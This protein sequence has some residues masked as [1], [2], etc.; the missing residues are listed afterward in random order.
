VAISRRGL[1]IGCSALGAAVGLGG[2][3]LLADEGV[4]PGR[5][6]LDTVLGRC[7]IDTPP[8][9]EATPGP[10]FR[11]SFYSRKRARSVNYM[12]GFPPGVALNAVLPVCLCLHGYG[13]NERAAFDTLG[14]H[15]LL[16]AA[17]KATVAPFVLASVDGGGGYW[18][19]HP[20][21]D[22]LGMLT[23]EFPVIL[24]QHGLPVDRFA[25]LGW[26]MGGFGALLAASEQ[27]ATYAAVVANAPAF[28]S[29]YGDAHRVN[30]GAFS[31]QEE[32]DT[33]GDL[34]QRVEGLRNTKLRIDCGES[35]PFEPVVS[36]L[37]GVL[38]DPSVVHIA[39]GCH[40]PTFWRS[41]APLQL[42]MIGEALSVPKTT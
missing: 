26:S 40:E 34:P 42:S 14:Y 18:H 17:V 32:W 36:D 13:E 30:P 21:D 27:P 39:K 20:G 16:A 9:A 35:D 6:V 29:S 5:S 10:T 24:A 2:W 3:E 4:V 37:R 38:P 8:P 15:K 7:T 41:L 19:P 33:W 25:L 23:T 11:S 1:I 31:S 22:P 12:L 28:W